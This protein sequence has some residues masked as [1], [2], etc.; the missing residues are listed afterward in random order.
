MGSRAEEAVEKAV[1]AAIDRDDNLARQMKQDDAVIDRH[2]IEIDDMAIH[3]LSKAPLASDLRLITVAM[4]ISRDLER[5]GDEATTIARQALELNREAPLE[6]R[7]EVSRMAQVARELLR[8]ALDA[9]VHHAPDKARALI[10]R[11]V[12][13]DNLNKQLHRELVTLMLEQSQ[14]IERCMHW[15]RISKSL[16][17]IAD[18]ATNIAEE[19]VYLYEG[20][21]IRHLGKTNLV[22]SPPS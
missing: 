4:K 16:E 12:E 3:L 13:V 14:A 19:V 8:T 7:S 9:F 15:I 22:S 20:R 18:H 2:E 11:D 17:R 6:A 1:K 21:D 10:P 5:V